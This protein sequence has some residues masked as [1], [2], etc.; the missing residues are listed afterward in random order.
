MSTYAWLSDTHF[1]MVQDDVFEKLVQSLRQ[2]QAVGIWLTGD[3]AESHDVEYWLMR[4]TKETELPVFFV[5]GNHDF[6]RSSITS[7][8]A[9][10]EMLHQREQSLYWLDRSDPMWITEST[11][12]VGVG[13]WGDARAGDFENTPIRIND[14]RLIQ[15]LTGHDRVVLK[16]KLQD[17][18]LEMGKRLEQKLSQVIT[19]HTIWILTH[20]PPFREACWYQGNAGDPNWTPD[21]VCAAVGKVLDQFAQRYPNIQIQ[22]LCGHGH[23][24][25]VLHRQKN[26]M[27][28]TA[29][30]EY[31]SPAVEMYWTIR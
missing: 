29:A 16:T 24:R 26:M 14:H 23:N 28:Y 9:Q 31:R 2:S 27:V 8:E 3:I 22:V 18:G 19:A 17:L 13:G 12:V 7:V 4:L 21:F 10:M 25:G 20:V 30:A 6:Y 15:E 1:N 5:L 11:A